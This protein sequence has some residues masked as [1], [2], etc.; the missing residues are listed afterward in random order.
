MK[1]L[2]F[3]TLLSTTIIATSC[4]K[5]AETA[6]ELPPFSS[7]AM[8]FSDFNSSTNTTGK[9]ATD[10]TWHWGRAAVQVGVWNY[11]LA[12]N[13]A[14]P[15]AAFKEAFNH[16]ATYVEASKEWMWTYTVSNEN[17]TY[18]AKLYALVS[19][20]TVSWRML[21]S[22]SGVYSDFEWF[23]G[24]SKLDQTGG[25]W[26][27]NSDPLYKLKFIDIVWSKSA[28]KEEIKYTNVIPGHEGNGSYIN[29][30]IEFGADLDAFYD[31]YL[32]KENS[33]E[34]IKWNTTNK[35]GKV[36]EPAY[37]GD[38]NYRCWGTDLANTI[39]D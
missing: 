22:Q 31:I 1:K 33:I 4:K 10:T 5:D 18:T 3:L 20:K 16:E 38:D 23:T 2:F 15:V 32:K 26:S 25:S 19:G 7:L 37:Y 29:Y 35:N 39:C 9:I 12:V 30:G 34:N 11:V 13:L 36:K 14:V 21:L 24:V 8:D 28:T 17:A 27:L 6:P